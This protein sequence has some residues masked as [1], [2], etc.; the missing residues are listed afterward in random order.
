MIERE[1]KMQRDQILRVL[2]AHRTELRALGVESLALFGSYARDTA[3]A[4]SDVD[5]L[6]E[7][8]RPV[9]LFA[10]VHLQL[11]LEALL[12]SRVDLVTPDAVRPTMR[13]QILQEAIDAS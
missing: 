9:G 8:N 2:Q 12:D 4:D 3:N 11:Q 1:I 10:Y 13:E 5:L 7:F 6:V